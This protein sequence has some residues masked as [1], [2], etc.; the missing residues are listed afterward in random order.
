LR[1]PKEF[2][3]FPPSSALE[4]WSIKNI[5][6][7]LTENLGLPNK[8]ARK[9]C[10]CPNEMLGKEQEKQQEEYQREKQGRGNYHKRESLKRKKYIFSN[11]ENC[12]S[13]INNF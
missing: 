12:W 7:L 8:V 11:K 6:L 9:E 1:I 4:T 2:L 3:G 5:I 10:R 13:P